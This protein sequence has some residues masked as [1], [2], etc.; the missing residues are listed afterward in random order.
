MSKD[1][2]FDLGKGSWTHVFDGDEKCLIK[3][4]LKGGSSFWDTV[5][6][7]VSMLMDLGVSSR[8]NLYA[9][10]FIGFSQDIRN[11]PLVTIM[12]FF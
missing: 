12:S 6:V 4:G 9:T 11:L 10:I 7:R 5:D 8:T 1:S 3:K 2:S